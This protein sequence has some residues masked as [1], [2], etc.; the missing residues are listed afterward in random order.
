[1]VF[2]KNLWKNFLFNRS[3]GFLRDHAGS[4]LLTLYKADAWEVK[5]AA[6]EPGARRDENLR[7]ELLAENAEAWEMILHDLKILRLVLTCKKCGCAHAVVSDLAVGRFSGQPAQRWS[8]ELFRLVQPELFSFGK[9]RLLFCPRCL[10]RQ[11]P[12]VRLFNGR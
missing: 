7:V 2:A 3:Y 9:G 6:D 10:T 8:C 11:K 5:D 1:M 4:R 12:W